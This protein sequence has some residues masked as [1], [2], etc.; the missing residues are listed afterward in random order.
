V[1]ELLI[2]AGDA[3]NTNP[4]K[5]ARGCYK[6]GD[7]VVVFDNGWPWGAE[8]LKAPI[9]G[10][11]F[12]VIKITDVTAD[13]VRAWLQN[14]WSCF[15]DSPRLDVD[16]VTVLARRRIKIDVDLVPAGVL[17]TL[18]QT[19]QFSTTW[20]QIRQFVHDKQTDQTAAGSPI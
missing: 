16:G 12:V 1:A 7:F 9:N 11:K 2:K 14:H 20:T 13:Q 8:E 19:G 4:T 15:V 18:N 6:R 5:D 10:G 3:V 17:Q